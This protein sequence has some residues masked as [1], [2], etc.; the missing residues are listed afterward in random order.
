MKKLKLK[1]V[2]ALLLC[3]VMLFSLVACVPG[4]FTELFDELLRQSFVSLVS[5]DTLSMHFSLADPEAYGVTRP[6]PTLGVTSRR[7]RYCGW[8]RNSQAP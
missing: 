5:A 1:S 8:Q 6:E 3:A 4:N 7:H 2:C